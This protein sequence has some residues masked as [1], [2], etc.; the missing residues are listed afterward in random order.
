L[1]RCVRVVSPCFAESRSQIR[2]QVPTADPPLPALR[3]APWTGERGPLTGGRNASEVVRVGDSV[4]RSRDHGRAT[5]AV[6]LGYLESAGYPHAPRYLGTDDCGRDTLTYISGQT[7]NHPS[8]RADGAYARGATMLRE[9]H[10][11]AAG[12]PLAAGRECVLHGDAGP[13]NTIFQAGLPAAFID[14]TWCIQT[15]S[16]ARF[17]L[18]SSSSFALAR[19]LRAW[20][21]S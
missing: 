17:G 9:L 5:A 20:T 14:W 1:A 7:A 18:V 10:D 21:S 13:F 3:K 16:Y 15:L 12:H 2:S 8:Q 6:L 19:S 4:R 11:L